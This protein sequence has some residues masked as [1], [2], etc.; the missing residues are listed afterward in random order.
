MSS[1]TDGCQG[2][3]LLYGGPFPQDLL[4][5]N[6]ADCLYW[7]EDAKNDFTWATAFKDTRDP[8]SKL[9]SGFSI[10]VSSKADYIL[11]GILHTTQDSQIHLKNYGTK[12][13][14]YGYN[15]RTQ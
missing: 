3:T 15:S 2:Q 7:W 13:S 6:S 10:I 14:S 4:S 9:S 5:F 12:A 8:H 1:G 11:S